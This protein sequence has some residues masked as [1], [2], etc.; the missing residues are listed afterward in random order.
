MFN[1]S[2]IG[3]DENNNY[4]LIEHNGTLKLFEN[5]YLHF[6]KT[7]AYLKTQNLN[8]SHTEFTVSFWLKINNLDNY[9]DLNIFTIDN[10]NIGIKYNFKK[11]E[12]FIDFGNNILK[13]FPPPAPIS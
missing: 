3:K 12:Y 13:S 10:L 9:R 7:Q 5:K 6:D 1:N 8:L 4:N 11:L 2:N